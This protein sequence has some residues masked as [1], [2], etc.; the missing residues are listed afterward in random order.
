MI[1]DA[2]S[3][4]APLKGVTV[5]PAPPPPEAQPHFAGPLLVIGAL[6]IAALIFSRRRRKAAG[7]IRVLE[8]TSLGPKRSLVVAQVGDETVLF[9]SSEGGITLLKGGLTPAAPAPSLS[10]DTL[11]AESAEDQDL[12]S[13]LQAGQHVRVA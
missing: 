12:R 4:A 7:W 1:T 9:G 6:A 3:P 2:P 13:K 10:F 8:T 11:L 5:Q